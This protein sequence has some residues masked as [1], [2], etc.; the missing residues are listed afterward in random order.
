MS[1]PVG[2]FRVIGEYDGMFILTIG[3]N[4][5][6]DLEIHPFTPPAFEDAIVSL[7]PNS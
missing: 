5:L 3:E 7:S 4:R 2:N 1:D 6:L